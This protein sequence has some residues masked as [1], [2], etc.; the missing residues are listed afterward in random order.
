MKNMNNSNKNMLARADNGFN[1]SFAP[2]LFDFFSRP[3][4]DFDSMF[5]PVAAD[6]ARVDIKD[7]GDRYQ[8]KA[9]MPGVKKED[10][11]VDFENVDLTIRAEH[12]KECNKKDEFGF[13][14]HERSEGT[15]QRTFHFDDADP[16]DITAAFANGELDICLMK[17]KK[18][19]NSTSI[20]IH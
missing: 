15:Y 12:H 3:L 2:T 19:E 4:A 17:S 14:V 8:L 13:M 11:R 18:A 9:D 5:A 20:K 6:N 10:I 7:L 1:H 16:K